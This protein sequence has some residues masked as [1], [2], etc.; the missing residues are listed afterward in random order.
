MRRRRAGWEQGPRIAE[1]MMVEICWGGQMDVDAMRG[2]FDTGRKLI[3][4]RFSFGRE[5]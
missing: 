3:S 4:G 2:W 5:G 1:R